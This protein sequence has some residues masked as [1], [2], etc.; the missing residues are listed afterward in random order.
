MNIHFADI[1]TAAPRPSAEQKLNIWVPS[2]AV[3]IHQLAAPRAPRRKWPDLVPWMLEDRLLQPP[4]Q[5]HFVILKRQGD[6]LIV[7]ATAKSSMQEWQGALAEAGISD[8]RLLP[9]FLALPWQPGM[10]SV[11]RQADQILVR[12]GEL[13]GFAAAPEFAWYML[14]KL[15]AGTDK[16]GLALYMPE[17]DLP[18][19]FRENIQLSRHSID[20]EHARVIDEADLLQGEFALQTAP[21]L[22][23]RSLA[24]AALVVLALFL[25]Y[26]S[27]NLENRHLASEVEGLEAQNRSDFY[28]L[29]PGLSIRSG[30]IRST[31]ERYISDRFL[32][33]DSLASDAMQTLLSLDEFISSCDCDLQGLVWQ[34]NSLQLKLPLSA[35]TAVEGLQLSGYEKEVSALAGDGLTLTLRREYAP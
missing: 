10:L 32:Q 7:L 8:Y 25:S 18:E 3:A 28:R 15:L 34:D 2:A 27:L 9:D 21:L 5:M 31:I 22:P 12:Y 19:Q 23:R 14:G 11:G 35:E 13:E 17:Q 1:Q 24:T 16:P 4:E 33:R 20:W 30:D 26:L 29:F 6:Q